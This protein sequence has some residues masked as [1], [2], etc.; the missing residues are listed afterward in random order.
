MAVVQVH[1]DRYTL[2][3]STEGIWSFQRI[4]LWNPGSENRYHGVC[5]HVAAEAEPPQLWL[6][7]GPDSG[8]A[9]QAAGTPPWAFSYVAKA[10]VQ[11]LHGAR[12][13]RELR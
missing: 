3:Q 4:H 2:S 5:T 11:T 10:S 8:K 6:F 13:P 7:L 12:S 1:D 9:L